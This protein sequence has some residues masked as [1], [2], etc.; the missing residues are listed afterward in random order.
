M[1]AAALIVASIVGLYISIF[2]T[3]VYYSLIQP[4]SKLVPRM[5][6][7][8]ESAC[9]NILNHR[10]AR[11]FGIPNSVM[12]VAFYTLILIVVIFDPAPSVSSPAML[13]SWMALLASFY[14]SYS[15][16]FTMWTLC[17]LCFVCHGLNLIIALLL[18]MQ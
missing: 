18:T 15:L 9:R 3:L 17:V 13:A 6:R 2:F 12:G 8:E 4:S 14:L 5:C 1:K 16:L 7:V 10:N 11:L